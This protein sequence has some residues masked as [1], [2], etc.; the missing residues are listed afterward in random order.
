MNLQ[1]SFDNA[2]TDSK[3]LS[4][5]P[6]NDVLLRLYSL[7]KQSTEGDVVGD[8]PSNPFD[9]VGLAK[10]NAWSILKGIEPDE[11]KKQ[12]VQLVESLK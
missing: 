2:V 1:E 10:H 9:F 7:Y 12:Y 6:G 4:V 3:L 11:A 8:G 5:K